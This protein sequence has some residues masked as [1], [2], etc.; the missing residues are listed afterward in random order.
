MSSGLPD[1]LDALLS[2]L[3]AIGDLT[4]R[5]E[6]VRRER[7]L[8][9]PA[10]VA[11]LAER[12]TQ[13][14]RIDL[15]KSDRLAHAAYWIA[16][17]IGDK[18]SRGLAMR[19][20]AHV[21]Y[22]RAKYEPALRYYEA[23]LATMRALGRDVEVG[24]T[25]SS[26][27][28]TMIYLGRYTDALAWA[29][30]ARAIFEKHNDRLRLSRLDLNTANILYRQDRFEEALEL[31]RRACSEFQAGAGA[32]QDVAAALSNMA[33]TCISLNDFPTALRYY[34]EARVYCARN[35][36]PL[37]VAEAD[38]NIAYLHYLRGEYTLAIKLYEDARK[39]CAELGDPYHEALCDLD[40]SEMYIELN[41]AED[42]ARLAQRAFERFR[43]L[44]LGYETAKA[45]AN[46]AIAASHEG[47]TQ[48]AVDLFRE[49]RGLFQLEHNRVWPALINLYQALVLE[50]ASRLAEARRLARSAYR[51]FSQSQLANKA[52]LCELLLAR[53]ELQ[54][55][56]LERSANLCAG[57]LKRVA[58][59]ESP[60]LAYQTWFVLGQVREARGDRRGAYRAFRRAHARLE[61]LRSQLR[62][63][64]LK[65][66]FLQDKLTVYENLFSLSLM[67]NRKA[68]SIENAFRYIEQA[69]SRSLTD[70]IAFRAQ[71]LP[72]AAAAGARM[73]IDV[74]RLREQLNSLYHRLD[75]LETRPGRDGE[76]PVQSLR[77]RIASAER[78]LIRLMQKMRATDRE[79]SS[80]QAS[81]PVDL[82]R[83]RSGIPHNTAIIEY[84]EARSNVYA[85]LL[86][87]DHLKCFDLGPAAK[88]R[89]TFR[90]LQFQL[91]KF[92]L[93]Q[94][95]LPTF[96]P[97]VEAVTHAHLSTLR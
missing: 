70:L 50:R 95:Y 62:G 47:K 31:Y 80:L 94:S 23:A 81:A 61:D 33:V 66:A 51:F 20:L 8:H 1:D 68:R 12:V 24:R 44:G 11:A 79:F 18:Y 74:R 25:L 5:R 14:V 65:I 38:Y 16:R 32:P 54:A 17:I 26:A 45:I 82:E 3:V 97:S 78:K 83:I 72:A 52:A 64:E 40:Q 73:A 19:A 48:R 29:D 67:R 22:S 89:E 59:A 60:A 28:H 57:A 30:E 76:S 92:R 42:G 58:G 75:I 2:K 77:D 41:L 37:L 27:L 43:N 85:L 56:R 69:K 10:G 84:Y 4:R 15:D 36:M 49:A 55:G 21:L 63:E 87:R 88:V 93:G 46:L 39:H 35:A 86:A 34:R 9:S 91:S 6:F 96:G 13:F 53:L 90:L 7:S 71:A